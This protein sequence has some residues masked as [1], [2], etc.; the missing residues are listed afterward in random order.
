MSAPKLVLLFNSSAQPV[1]AARLHAAT[2]P[3]VNTGKPNGKA[4]KVVRIDA[5]SATDIADINEQGY[6]VKRCKCC[7][8]PGRGTETRASSRSR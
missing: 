2:C 4:G 6:P 5:P 1:N 8:E 7:K 3:M